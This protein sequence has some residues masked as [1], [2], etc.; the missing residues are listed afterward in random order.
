MPA[1]VSKPVEFQALTIADACA[2]KLETP[3]MW[4]KNSDLHSPLSKENACFYID[5]SETI[6]G[7]RPIYLINNYNVIWLE[8]FL[9]EM[10]QRHKTSIGNTDCTG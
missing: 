10:Q 6:R 8:R 5:L 2:E 4:L 9:V 3:Q 1:F 7:M